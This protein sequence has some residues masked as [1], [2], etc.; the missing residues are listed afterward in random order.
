M[1]LPLLAGAQAEEDH[2]P[3][4]IFPVV[5]DPP[6][7][8]DGVTVAPRGIAFRQRLHSAKAIRLGG[9]HTVSYLPQGAKTAVQITLPAQTLFV[10]ARDRSGEIYCS[11][12]PQD[13]NVVARILLG[14]LIDRFQDAGICLR[15]T[16]GDGTIDEEIVIDQAPARTR[17]AYELIGAGKAVWKPATV[18]TEPVDPAEI[19]AAEL[20]VSYDYFSGGLFGKRYGVLYAMLCWP[21]ALL[22][23]GGQNGDTAECANLSWDQRGTGSNI[24]AGDGVHSTVHMAYV[25]IEAVTDKHNN[26][27]VTVKQPLI[28]GFGLVFMIGRLWLS[29]TPE[30]QRSIVAILPGGSDRDSGL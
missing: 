7:S 18:A 4:I 21:E 24:G 22:P 16:N 13:A 20:R 12:V 6:A 29:P 28:P 1:A 10:L 17:I 5:I 2:G 27:T 25:T 14:S 3:R 19:P 11:A 8:P 23:P 26:A 15:D 9:A 30:G